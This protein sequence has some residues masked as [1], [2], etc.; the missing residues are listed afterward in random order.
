MSGNISLK[1]RP[2]KL[3][4]LVEPNDSA[5]LQEAIQ[6]SS[7]LWGGFYNPIIPCFKRVPQ[8]W[9]ELKLKKISPA[10]IIQGYLDAFDPDFLV[11]LGK[12]VDS[13][14]PVGNRKIIT[15]TDILSSVTETHLPGYGVGL[16]ELLRHLYKEEF[17]FVR[18]NPLS[19]N[20]PQFSQS[21]EL[22]LSSVLGKLPTQI[23]QIFWDRFAEEIEAKSENCT[24][25][26]FY[27]FFE[28]KNLFL[29]RITSSFIKPSPPK[30]PNGNCIFFLDASKNLDVIDYWNLRAIGWTVVP[31]PKQGLL[32]EVSKKFLVDFVNSNYLPMRFN[33]KIY[34]S[35]TILKSRTVTKEDALKFVKSLNFGRSEQ[36][37]NP[38]ILL[39]NWYP[40][41]W[42]EWARDSDGVM[43]CEL[44]S[45]NSHHNFDAKQERISIQSLAPKFINHSYF[46]G[47]PRYANV[48]EIR[49][50]GD[51]QFY[52]EVIPEGGRELAWALG[53]IGEN[54]RFSKSG[55]IY[56][57]STGNYPIS[58]KL[59]DAEELFRLWLKS[60]GWNCSLSSPGRIAKQMQKQFGNEFRLHQLAN[61]GLIKLLGDKMS[62]GK[63]L[64]EKEFRAEIH[65]IANKRQM[66]SY[67]DGASIIYTLTDMQ[68]FRLGMEIQ[69]PTCSKNSWYS[70]K[71]ADYD[72]QC[73]KC[74]DKFSIRAEFTRN[75]KW[76]YRTF[77]PFSLPAKAD[78]VYTVLL[79]LR[80]FSSTIR[81]WG[82]TTP[83]MSFE[84]KKGDVEIEV[85]LGLFFQESSL[86]KKEVETIFAE[87]K[88]YK[89]FL[90][91]DVD[92]M[93][94]L[95]KN[96]PGAIIVFATLRKELKAKELTML[97]A[98]ASK[99]RKNY[100]AEKPSNTIIILT[101][102]ELFADNPPPIC[103]QDAG[104]EIP[105][106][107]EYDSRSELM[108]LSDSTQQL[109]LGME[110]WDTWLQNNYEKK[111][112]KLLSR[113]IKS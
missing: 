69:C 25:D 91:K 15:V 78:G 8:N 93:D 76:S 53:R 67:G 20:L 3:A 88:T 6:I 45:L 44:E 55:L 31:A 4:F 68:M 103:W 83:I 16:F 81:L 21:H 101:G 34:N 10:A 64:N 99:C 65:K 38:K 40:R 28:P 47:K 43:C 19:I 113:K 54:E 24:I 36:N 2:I 111:R 59:P 90:K 7:F 32:S 77:G 27:K 52:A 73:P 98:F 75:L 112:E 51:K 82:T 102:N 56:F 104:L 9:Q 80:F 30:W 22:F 23:D 49:F 100:K 85:D 29:R 58:L 110:P 95:A 66:G 12:C 18:K 11:P 5:A 42:D 96:F 39:Q 33:P 89:E 37:E 17:K 94:T 79:T 92:K 62:E 48:V 35:T 60:R 61:E 13:T 109:Y 72:L 105:S 26:D 87:C 108:R 86:G 107:Y 50:Y 41:I 84:A 1:L 63:P 71:D 14:Y 74:L 57:Q 97:R 46:S 106:S 70:I